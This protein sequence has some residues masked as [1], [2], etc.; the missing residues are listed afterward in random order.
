MG[1]QDVGYGGFGAFQSDYRISNIPRVD[2][3][4]AQ[5]NQPQE[6]PSEI[7]KTEAPLIEEV[8]L[9]PRA[10][11]PN[12][13]SLTFDKNSDFSYIGRDKDLN[14]LDIEKAIS[15]MK[16]DG[17]LKEY[18]YFVGSASNVYSSEDGVVIAKMN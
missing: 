12:S 7:K 13:V 3:K 17:I 5:I 11:D 8:D 10:T 4:S 2:E 6:Q 14:D 1:I 15:D 18:Q 16:Q 9:R